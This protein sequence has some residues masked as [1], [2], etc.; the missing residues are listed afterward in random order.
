MSRVG[1]GRTRKNSENG[2]LQKPLST[3]DE[4]LQIP[5]IICS[6]LPGVG[7]YMCVTI[8]PAK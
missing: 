2:D 3:K 1:N 8:F 5:M 6:V 4:I 7:Q